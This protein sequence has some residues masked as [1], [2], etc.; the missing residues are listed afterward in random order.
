MAGWA[1]YRRVRAR[2]RRL[3]GFVAFLLVLIMA[4]GQAALAQSVTL[5]ISPSTFSGAGSTLTY[6]LLIEPGAYTITSINQ[7]I[8]TSI[9]NVS[10][11]CPAL[12]GGRLEFPSTLTCTGAYTTDALDASAGSF[13]DI[14]TVNA[15]RFGPINFSMTS[16]NMTVQQAGGGP[17]AVSVTSTPNASRP[18]ELVTVTATVGSLGCNAGSAPPGTA[19]ITV[20]SQSQTVAL[21]SPFPGSASS[22]ASFVT[23]TLPVGTHAVSATYGGGSNCSPG[24]ATGANQIVDTDPAVSIN[25]AAGQADP[26]GQAPVLFSVVYDKPVTGFTAG[27]VQLSGTAGPTSVNVSGSGANYTVS[28]GGMTR[29]GT[30]IAT[31]P[32]N[33]AVGALSGLPNTASTSTD[34][35][36]QYLFIEISP[37]SLPSSTY[38]QPYS[39]TITASGGS[40]PHSFALSGSLPAGMAFSSA[41]VLSGTPTA[42]GNFNF[43][44]T[45][46]DFTGG[47]NARSYTLTVADPTITMSPLSLPDAAIGAAYAQTIS[48]TGGTSPYGFALTAGALPAGLS[49]ESDGTLSGTPTAAG[50]FNFTVTGTDNSPNTGPYT[51]SR[52]YTVNVAPPTISVSP[53]PVRCQAPSPL[54]PTARASPRPV[55]SA[56]TVS[57]SPR[58]HCL[59]A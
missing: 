35:T 24:S 22:Q 44:V 11:T 28:V 20:G 45:A 41:G 58:A 12:P 16:N 38:G 2:P 29:T 26:T 30:V 19:T 42:S 48:A 32:A 52:A 40:W 39:E 9:K 37:A 54:F 36:V 25:Q 7:P 56:R 17:V 21:I 47:S 53:P 23:S 34:N 3:T 1:C 33:A 10:I 6:N 43:I 5:S 57:R 49:L 4:G 59:Q 14:A 18:A 27:D 46:T 15:T 51:A 8:V 13:A 50:S 55:A 31:I